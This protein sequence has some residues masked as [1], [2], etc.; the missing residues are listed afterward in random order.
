MWTVCNTSNTPM[1]GSN[2]YYLYLSIASRLDII[3]STYTFVYD[4]ECNII[5][6]T[7]WGILY[8]ESE[9]RHLYARE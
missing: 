4:D 5:M 6:L 7:P 2:I 3:N 1:N 8:P 9:K